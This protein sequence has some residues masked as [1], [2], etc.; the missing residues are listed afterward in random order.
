M[1][2][3]NNQYFEEEKEKRTT[4]QTEEVGMNGAARVA[5]SRKKR[6]AGVLLFVF[7]I[8]FCLSG[9]FYTLLYNNNK[10]GANGGVTASADVEFDETVSA[11]I[12]EEWALAVQ[13]LDHTHKIGDDNYSLKLWDNWGADVN[14]AYSFAYG[15]TT[16]FTNGGI[17]CPSGKTV[18]LDLNGYTVSRRL[19]AS[20]A[21][22]YVITSAGT[23]TIMDSS[24]DPDANRSDIDADGNF[25]QNGSGMITGGY[26]D[27]SSGGG[28]IL[29]T[30]GTT[31]LRSGA[32]Y[33]NRSNGLGGGG[34]SVS[35]GKLRAMGGAI[36][37]NY[38]Y[39]NGGAIFQASGTMSLSNCL[40]AQNSISAY[41][42]SAV[43]MQK[44]SAA[45]TN[46]RFINHACKNY[47]IYMDNLTTLTFTDCYM[48]GNTGSAGILATATTVS[49]TNFV[50]ENNRATNRLFHIKPTNAPTVSGGVFRNNVIS[51]VSAVIEFNVAKVVTVE[52]VLFEGNSVGS[53]TSVN[54]SASGCIV[55]HD[56][57]NYALNVRGCTFKDNVSRANG[58]SYGASCVCTRRPLTLADCVFDHNTGGQAPVW[59][60]YMAGSSYTFT[61]T[62]CKFIN[63]NS[64][65]NAS[66]IGFPKMGATTNLRGCT[67]EGN[68]GAYLVNVPVAISMAA[69]SVTNEDESVTTY[70]NIVKDNSISSALF[71]SGTSISASGCEFTDNHGAGYLLRAGTSVTATNCEFTG[72]DGAT[73]CVY[74]AAANTVTDCMFEDNAV[75]TG[76][77]YGVTTT[78]NNV[79]FAG[80]NS[81]TNSAIQTTGVTKVDN[82][83]FMGVES[84]STSVGNC[85]HATNAL[86][87]TNSTFKGNNGGVASVRAGA[88]S[89]YENLEFKNNTAQSAGGIYVGGASAFRGPI[90]VQNN[91]T[92]NGAAVF[93][94]SSASLTMSGAIRVE[95]NFWDDGGYSRAGANFYLA[96]DT[97]M[98]NIDGSLAGSR[99]Y[100]GSPRIGLFTSGFG[101]NNSGKA[102][103]IFKTDNEA[104]YE[105][106]DD[107]STGSMEGKL[108]YK[109]NST[110]WTAAV[111][112]S[113]ADGGK[114]KT[115]KLVSDWTAQVISGNYKRF[116]DTVSVNADN[117][118]SKGY[119]WVSTSNYGALYVPTGASV[120]L[121]LNGYTINR[122]IGGAIAYGVVIYIGGGTLTI[123]DSSATKTGE[124][125]QVAEGVS[126][127]LYQPNT[128]NGG[129]TGGFNSTASWAGGIFIDSGGV[130][131][132]LNLMAGTIYDNKSNAQY[133]AGGVSIYGANAVFT[134]YGGA[135]SGNVAT[136]TSNYG[137]GGV[138]AASNGTV[139]T[140]KG[141]EISG[142]TC[143]AQFGAGGVYNSATVNME[144]GR[145]TANTASNKYS[146]G[147]IFTGNACT[148]NITG[149]E[150][151][152]NAA[153][154]STAGCGGIELFGAIF[155]MS[156]AVVHNNHGVSVGGVYFY[157]SSCRG[158][159]ENGE[160]LFSNVQITENYST[161]TSSSTAGGIWIDAGVT[162]VMDS[163]AISGNWCKS[164]SENTAGGI[165]K[166]NGAGTLHLLGT[167][168]NGKNS[169]VISGNGGGSVGGINLNH[170]TVE[171][172]YFSNVDFI[173]NYSA[174]YPLAGALRFTNIIGGKLVMEGCLFDGNYI[175]ASASTSTYSHRGGVMYLA[176]CAE[177]SDCTFTNNSSTHGAGAINYGAP[178]CNQHVTLER[179]VFT[180]NVSTCS[181]YG[182]AIHTRVASTSY[183]DS[184]TLIDCTVGAEGA[185][186]AGVTTG[187]IHVPGATKTHLT[188]IG[189]SVSYNTVTAATSYAAIYVGG[190][191]GSCYFEKDASGNGVKIEHN[192]SAATTA[193]ATVYVTNGNDFHMYGGS[194]SYN[195]NTGAGSTTSSVGAGL[196]IMGS[197]SSEFTVEDVIFSGNRNENQYDTTA[198]E[199]SGTLNLIN[200]TVTENVGKS[201]I[202]HGNNQL[203]L[204][205]C[206]VTNNRTTEENSKWTYGLISSNGNITIKK[207][208]SLWHG[209]GSPESVISGN[210]ANSWGGL[211]YAY[212]GE[213]HVSDTLIN[214][215]TCANELSFIDS[216]E[217]VFDN[218]IFSDNTAGTVATAVNYGTIIC[219][220]HGAAVA[221]NNC[222]FTGN[223]GAI[224]GAVQ[225]IEGAV[226]ATDCI[227][228]NNQSLS[229]N[230]A[231]AV[232]VNGSG[233]FHMVNGSITNNTARLYRNDELS[234][235]GIYVALAGVLQLEGLVTVKDNLYVSNSE[236]DKT[237]NIYVARPSNMIQVVGTLVNNSADPQIGIYRLDLGDFTAGFGCYNAGERAEYYFGSDSA[238]SF[239]RTDT[240]GDPCDDGHAFR[241][242]MIESYDN[243]RNW[244]YYV[245]K[246]LSDGGKHYTVTL[247]GDWIAKPDG[248]TYT[249]S[250]GSDKNA[251]YYGALRVPAGANITLELNGHTLDRNLQAYT[252]EVGRSYGHVISVQGTFNLQNSGRVATVQGI[253]VGA[254]VT[255]VV[256]GARNHTAGVGTIDVSSATGKFT[257]ISGTVSGNSGPNTNRDSG[258][259]T[260]GVSVTNGARFIMV[261]G[262]IQNNYGETAGGVYVDGKSQFNLYSGSIVNNSAAVTGGVHVASGGI[263]E[264]GSDGMTYEIGSNV[265]DDDLITVVSASLGKILIEKNTLDSGDE[266]NVYTEADLLINLYGTLAAGTHVG[267]S[268]YTLS[269][270]TNNYG[271]YHTVSGEA[272]DPTKYFTSDS[273]DYFVCTEG[274]GTAAE[275]MMMSYNNRDN[276]TYAVTTSLANGGA[277]TVFKLYANP[278]TKEGWIAEK[279]GKFG[280]FFGTNTQAYLT[281]GALWVPKGANI[282]LDLRHHDLDRNLT[283]SAYENGCVIYVEGTLTVIDSLDPEEA[284]SGLASAGVP[285]KIKGGNNSTANAAGGIVV[286]HGG[287]LNLEA[288][289]ITENVAGG[290]NSVGGVYVYGSEKTHFTMKGGSVSENDGFIAGGVYV[291]NGSKSGEEKGTFTMTGGTVTQNSATGSYT[292]G[293]RI[294]NTGVLELGGSAVIDGNSASLSPKSNLFLAD[295]ADTLSD[296]AKIEIAEPFRTGANI[297]LTRTVLGTFTN[298]YGKI[299]ADNGLTAPNPDTVFHSDAAHYTVSRTGDGETLEG[300]IKCDLPAVNWSYAVQTSINNGGAA[301]RF[302]LDGNW[303][304][305]D[306]T[307]AVL[308]SFGDGVGY[309]AGRLYVPSNASIILDLKGHTI[310]RNLLDK[311]TIDNGSVFF[312]FGSLTIVDSVGGGKITG[313][314]STGTGG[315]FNAGTLEIQ[316]GSVT[317]NVSASAENAAG[318]L[319]AGTLIMSGGSITGN[320][321]PHGGVYVETDA[322]IC[323]EGTAYINGNFTDDS[324]AEASNVYFKSETGIFNITGEMKDGADISFLREG[325]GE[326]TSGFGLNNK[327]AAGGNDP[328][329]YFTSESELYQLT[330][331]G[332][333]IKCEA[334]IFSEDNEINW[335]YF[336]AK[337]LENNSTETF[338]LYQNWTA[339]TD[340]EYTTAFGDKEK[341]GYLNGGLYVPAGASMILDLQGNTIDRAL[342]E[343]IKN[344]YVFIIE[345]SLTIIDSSATNA[346]QQGVITGGFSL[347]TASAIQIGGTGSVTFNAGNITGNETE[348]ETNGTVTVNGTFSM[349]GGEIADNTG[350]VNGGVY[351]PAKSGIFKLG[352][353]SQIY[354]NRNGEGEDANIYFE[355]PKGTI[356]VDAPFTVPGTTFTV[357]RS[358]IGPFTSGYGAADYKNV[359]FVSE[360]ATYTAITKQID[361]ILEGFMD[362]DDNA[363]LWEY[364]VQTSLDNEG[365]TEDF[366]LRSDWNAEVNGKSTAF[367]TKSPYY[368][369]GA[370]YVPAGASINFDLNGYALNRGLSGTSSGVA[371]GYVMNVAGDLTLNDFS[372]KQQG[373]FTGGFSATTVNSTGGV[374]VNKGA[375]FTMTGGH[376]SDNKASGAGG[377]AVFNNGTFTMTG[378]LIG[379]FTQ[380]DKSYGKNQGLAGAVYNGAHG[381]FVMEGGVITGNEGN[382]AGGVFVYNGYGSFTMTGGSIANNTGISAGGVYVSGTAS[383]TGGEITGNEATGRKVNEGGGSGVYIAS[384]GNF[385]MTGGKVSE[386]R[387]LNGIRAYSSGVLNMGG[388][389]QVL[390]NIDQQVFDATS[391]NEYRNVYLT[392]HT[393]RINIVEPLAEGARI[394]VT[395]DGAGIFT[396]GYGLVNSDIP[397]EYFF[398][399]VSAYGV[400][401]A[402]ELKDGKSV[403]EAAIGSPVTKP[404]AV[405]GLEYDATAHEI[406]DGFDPDKMTYVKVPE[407]ATYEDG[408]FTAV[409][410]G[411]YEFR[412]SP[413]NGYCWAD[414]TGNT[415]IVTV[416][417]SPRLVEL[418]WTHLDDLVY[419][420]KVRV[421]TA[422]VINL[423]DPDDVV[424][425]AVTV[426]QPYDG[427]NAGKHWAEA[428]FVDNPNYTLRGASEEDIQTEYTINKATLD[429]SIKNDKAPYKTETKIELVDKG[430]GTLDM[431]GVNVIYSITDGSGLD[432][433]Y[434][435]EGKLYATAASGTVTIKAEVPDTTNYYAASAT[436]ELE[437]VKGTPDLDL[438][439]DEDEETLEVEY[440]ADLTLVVTGNDGFDVTLSV[441]NGEDGGKALISGN[442]L[443]GKYVGT[444]TLTIHMNENDF[445]EETDVEV[446]V[447]VVPRVVELEWGTTDKENGDWTPATEGTPIEFT[448]NGKSQAPEAKVANAVFD[449]QLKVT[450]SGQ[451]NAGSYLEQNGEASEALMIRNLDGTVN[452]N[453]KIG[454]TTNKYQDFIIN[455]AKL[456]GLNFVN[457]IVYY[458][459]ELVLE[460]EGNLGGAKVTYTVMPDTCCTGNGTIKD[461]II[462]VVDENGD[463]IEQD[464]PLTDIFVPT[465]VGKVFVKATIAESDNYYGYIDDTTDAGWI[466]EYIQI[467]QGTRKV[468]LTSTKGTNEDGIVEVVY[469]DDFAL[470]LEGVLED[471]VLE[472]GALDQDKVTFTVISVTTSDGVIG[473]ITGNGTHTFKATEAGEVKVRIDV[474]ATE[475]YRAY[476]GV[477]T[478]IVKP[479]P[480]E[481]HWSFDPN[482][483]TFNGHEQGPTAVVVNKAFV[484]D[485]VNVTVKGN[486]NAGTELTASASGLTG[487]DAHNYTL[488]DGKYTTSG[489]YTVKPLEVEVEWGNTIL[490]FTG[491]EQAPSYTVYAV[492]DGKKTDVTK[493]CGLVIDGKGLHVGSYTAT[494]TGT[495]NTNY[496]VA[497]PNPTVDFRITKSTITLEITN[498]KLIYLSDTQITFTGNIGN[499]EVTYSVVDVDPMDMWSYVTIDAKTGIAFASEYF[500]VKVRVD[501]DGTNDTYAGFVEKWLTVERGEPNLGLDDGGDEENDPYSVYYGDKLELVFTGI[502]ADTTV[503]VTWKYDGID[504]DTYEPAE[505]EEV[506]EGRGDLSFNGTNYEILGRNVGKYTLVVHTSATSLHAES[507]QEIVITVKPRPLDITWE[508]EFKYDGTPKLLKMKDETVVGNLAF[509]DTCGISYEGEALEDDYSVV[510]SVLGSQIAIGAYKAIVTVNN[511]NYCIA[512]VDDDNQLDFSII[513]GELEISIE[514]E[515]IYIDDVDE[516]G[517][518]TNILKI[519]GNLGNGKVTVSVLDDS[520]KVSF[521]ETTYVLT[522]I[523]VGKV[524]VHIHIDETA[525]YGE[526]DG[527][528]E[529]EVKKHETDVELESTEFEYGTVVELKLTGDGAKDGENDRDVTYEIKEINVGGTK[530]DASIEDADF[531]P[532]WVGKVIIHVVVAGSENYDDAEFDVEVTIK[533]RVVEL[534][535]KV[536][537]GGYVYDG[538][539]QGPTATVK[540]IVSW[541]GEKDDVTVKVKGHV[542]AGVDVEAT[543]EKLEGDASENY[544]LPE[545][546]LT[547]QFTIDR[548]VLSYEWRYYQFDENGEIVKDTE[549]KPVLI[550]Y[551]KFELEY[552]GKEIAP[553]PYITSTLYYNEE[554]EADD[555]CEIEVTGKQINVIQGED[556][557]SNPYTATAFKPTNDNYRLADAPYGNE[558]NKDFIIVKATPHIKLTTTEA[559]FGK[560]LELK[561]TGNVGKGTETYTIVDPLDEAGQKELTDNSWTAGNAFIKNGTNVFT[562][563]ELGYVRVKISVAETENSFAAE[564]YAWVKV[565][566]GEM[567]FEIDKDE[568]IYG[569]DLEMELDFSKVVGFGTDLTEEGTKFT[570]KPTVISGTISNGVDETKGKAEEKTVGDYYYTITA[571]GAGKVEVTI[572]VK[573]NDYYKDT[574]LTFTVTIKPRTITITEWAD[575]TEFVY[576][577][578]EQYPAIKGLDNLASWDKVEDI[579]E[580]VQV[581]GYVDVTPAGEKYVATAVKSLNDNYV[582]DTADAESLKS[583]EYVITA[584]VV[585]FEW[586]YYEFDEDGNIVTDEDGNPVLIP[587]D[588]FKLPYTGEEI[589][590]I[591]RITNLPKDKDG[592]VIGSCEINVGGKEINVG[593]DYTATADSVTNSNYTLA[594]TKSETSVNFDIVVSKPNL[595]LTYVKVDYN[596]STGKYTVSKNQNLYYGDTV[597]LVLT[598]NIGEGEE[599]YSLDDAGKGTFSTDSTDLILGNGNVKQY[600]FLKVEYVG[601]ITVKVEV[602]ET[603]NTEAAETELTLNV[604]KADRNVQIWNYNTEAYHNRDTYVTYGVEAALMFKGLDDVQAE[605]ITYLSTLD[606]PKVIYPYTVRLVSRG[607][608][609][610]KNNMFPIAP[611]KNGTKYYSVYSLYPAGTYEEMRV[612]VPA[613][614]NYNA[615]VG[616]F[617]VYTKK[618]EIT[619]D[620]QKSEF[621]YNGKQQVPT[622]NLIGL[623]KEDIGYYENIY[624][625]VNFSFT[626]PN[627]SAQMGVDAGTYTAT[628]TSLGNTDY[629]YHSR[630]GNIYYTIVGSN[631]SYEYTIG[632]ADLKLVIT[633][634]KAA[635]GTD[636]QLKVSGNLGGGEVTYQLL[637][638]GS[639]SATLNGDILTPTGL[640]TVLVRASVPETKNY[641]AATSEITVITIGKPYAPIDVKTLEVMYG[642]ELTVVVDNNVE[643][644]QVLL[645]IANGTG[646][647]ELNGYVLTG[648]G[649]GTATLT[650]T[651]AETAT[652]QQTTIT[653]TV[654]IK[655]RP[656]EIEWDKTTLKLVY[657]GEVQAPRAYVVSG[658]INGDT[659]EVKVSGGQI[660]AG[661]Y[662]AKAV[663][664]TNP[665]Y[666][667]NDTNFTTPFEIVG[668]KIDV[669]L[670]NKVA[671]IGD[672]L[673][674]VLSGN[675][676]GG[677]VTYTILNT[678]EGAAELTGDNL[679]VLNPI[680]TGEVIVR[681]HVDATPNTTACDKDEI[682]TIKKRELNLEFKTT[683]VVYGDTLELDILG[684]TGNGEVSYTVTNHANETQGRATIQNDNELVAK[685]V[686]EVAVTVT[687]AVTDRYEET[688]LTEIITIKPRP[689]EIEWDKSKTLIYNGEE[690][691]PS[692]TVKPSSLVGSDTCLVTKIEG[693]IDAGTDNVATVIE[694][695]NENYTVEDGVNISTTYT[696][697]P[698]TV[699]LE[700]QKD[701]SFV[702][703]GT[704]QV[705]AAEVTNKA[706]RDKD[707][708][709]RVYVDGET[710]ANEWRK[711]EGES[712]VRATATATSIGIS[713]YTLDNGITTCTNLTV[714]YDI[715][716]APVNLEWKLDSSTNLTVGTFFDEKGEIVIAKSTRDGL[717]HNVQNNNEEDICWVEV[718]VSDGSAL[719]SA[720]ATFAA[721]RA[722]DTSAAVKTYKVEAF[723]VSNK[724]YDLDSVESKNVTRAGKGITAEW[725]IL[726]EDGEF[727]PVEGDIEFIY[728]GYE[729]KPAYRLIGIDEEDKD[730]V[731][732]TYELSE[733]SIN[734]GEYTIY[735]KLSGDKAGDYSF[736]NPDDMQKAFKIVPKEITVKVASKDVVMG[737][738]DAE[739][740]T[741]KLVLKNQK[742]SSWLTITSD[743]LAEPDKTKAIGDIFDISKLFTE[744]SF[745]QDGEETSP[746]IG[747]PGEYDIHLDLIKPTTL[748]CKDPK[749]YVVTNFE[750]EEK[751]K[752]TVTAGELEVIKLTE[753]STY[754]F[755]TEVKEVRNDIPYSYRRSY[756]T[757]GWTHGEDDTDLDYAVIG[758]ISK[759]TMI[760][761]FIG[762]I[763]E[764]Q[765][766]SIRVHRMIDGVDTLLY[767]CGTYNE[768]L[769]TSQ[770]LIATGTWVELVDSEGNVLDTVYLSVLGDA[771]GDGYINS[772]DKGNIGNY[773]L[774]VAIDLFDRVEYR[775]AGYIMNGGG[776][777]SGDAGVAGNV[778]FGKAT[779]EDYFD[780]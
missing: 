370:L 17:A 695:D 585:E 62:R 774:G 231:G 22:G 297:H 25:V 169:I 188:I 564:T 779:M 706:L 274:T 763:D 650:V 677:K 697:L 579:A 37:G 550:P 465:K 452:P 236:A 443:T 128:G 377:G 364:A 456:T 710:H 229:P 761:V 31:T 162:L 98:L 498:E 21:N 601:T 292:G 127:P 407:G 482:G 500:R 556:P 387:G 304:A 148:L 435:T 521:N 184:L 431:T 81:F 480:V 609:Y 425:V 11:A 357:T 258:V 120:I 571:K 96:G 734:A 215:N 145:I 776:I 252:G 259:H 542:N 189:G 130:H 534:E 256:T 623:A 333:G 441:A 8:L 453:Y 303:T 291:D 340:D 687:V 143:A 612:E 116:N 247:Y 611:S 74:S 524:K 415:I 437:L 348:S 642:D 88:N 43:R 660:A 766:K 227:I 402:T 485:V 573:G 280:T 765:R 55:A 567:A 250:F 493:V 450:T 339:K 273:S 353:S 477:A 708:S 698:R 526:F 14:N 424:N 747:G 318:V 278:T 416:V 472:G 351:I 361:G 525:D 284:K 288:G 591:A 142:N 566:K 54:G 439:K 200:C 464:D 308:T 429:L 754:Q 94:H 363:A 289:C 76:L 727:V 198:I 512:G 578:Q 771:N 209:N 115:C 195:I 577:A 253:N 45:F 735:L 355:S 756:K 46:V 749:N 478:V 590:P 455:K 266:K 113:L 588:E 181:G 49:V 400:S 489:N 719:S 165:Y 161:T 639:G 2:R 658:L 689:V 713:N 362:T 335:S 672:T 673:K 315:I 757:L 35:A 580:D 638:G 244:Q 150:I 459:E 376:I 182:G 108:F 461:R 375:T 412:F 565:V 391:P 682:V 449:D 140:M 102:T 28:G 123:I 726:D 207:D 44:G 73:Y 494:A 293:V 114:T 545:E 264:I 12:S 372:D 211:I 358:A 136:S 598:G 654:I 286:A 712:E 196:Y 487:K 522:P 685:H 219:A 646:S 717:Y 596:E 245:N 381:E 388:T 592:K 731:I 463:E 349:Y 715:D 707:L 263:F 302:T 410:A 56:Q 269:L 570:E 65:A 365:A 444:V 223:C 700:W 633:T 772:G 26:S 628:V 507:T 121:D 129:I 619:I 469:G 692:A 9:I 167:K 399:D 768:A 495:E 160:V 380:G 656:V 599:H 10:G 502:D 504:L 546:G 87:L 691:T 93:V 413:K 471:I 232:Y 82:C 212:K 80:A 674:L 374:L 473:D 555:E 614:E 551:E 237:V 111:Q 59:S 4:V 3:K 385:T 665:N 408:K 479:K 622:V 203:N 32:I 27:A 154:S 57:V 709:I 92:R 107:T 738:V 71:Y 657:N 676:G 711:A 234:S 655:P 597:L 531:S 163:G 404:T 616:Y 390:N 199:T 759:E 540:N 466:K 602:E 356:Y 316:A 185:G 583:G 359:T 300:F 773:Y 513:L 164:T 514:P 312:V 518:G 647:A 255:G 720:M 414:G 699:E 721:V 156:N 77:I 678:G 298:N 382:N 457:T 446:T 423:A 563:D 445:Y 447:K 204:I 176:S 605:F 295:K 131:G 221:L 746:A 60:Y 5:V 427:K 66:A 235:G 762:N 47:L 758:S 474:A 405:M 723:D 406:I 515:E 510:V 347:N 696:I 454:D 103:D 635:L 117:A 104:L 327:D 155:N 100:V 214:G 217:N 338:T 314:N 135:I 15:Q 254:P 519:I 760:D 460:L 448:Y 177:I 124:T 557:W 172:T 705:P 530:G 241:E 539:E 42:G 324:K 629:G 607:V 584:L 86:T 51:G 753:E 767:D 659:S 337:S 528:F 41:Y 626:S 438:E 1:K 277:E 496:K 574:E 106:T 179:C 613:T 325:L 621:T 78:V 275:A 627:A 492:L 194:V 368:I 373:V 421:P 220:D 239:V 683:E 777:V 750:F 320:Y 770:K 397:S 559:P 151:S 336:V 418:E 511:P 213:T 285:G 543:A 166:T 572:K 744:P 725:G 395:R 589:A 201:L 484:D 206:T 769:L 371:N 224:S 40:I 701:A 48:S 394:G 99:I 386:N 122:A 451:T 675:I 329:K 326:V 157:G 301:E 475:N 276:W 112:E 508:N 537:E 158:A 68:A 379:S 606:G 670:V 79:N 714:L 587:Y 384:T 262:A 631:L 132:V 458:G 736:E 294:N 352:G 265:G 668:A 742:W 29:V 328:L 30:G 643:K 321:G 560:D 23:F 317:G 532:L 664:P 85:I 310:D 369:N 133:T 558:H 417:I 604:V 630:N 740:F 67:F 637:T 168:E 186:N 34:I 366:K 582:L 562:P 251:F 434:L 210:T 702:Y 398:S 16:G 91:T 173:G 178:G 440:G 383:M 716:Q 296:G 134:M 39:N 242:G 346:E 503:T 497:T 549:G 89:T 745:W 58:G 279:G 729:Q 552:T 249:T 690:Q 666:C 216:G 409:N 645:G 331:Q 499:G 523:A 780:C 287:T 53:Y 538:T 778:Y 345:G 309:N 138:Y 618:K 728:N 270:F 505:D 737:Y 50:A 174:S 137:G 101:T 141:G 175:S 428:S 684:N 603:E 694:L 624:K 593:T 704:E 615:Y 481:L 411:S 261:N 732:V 401:E 419:T 6:L 125:V 636:L 344:G 311:A 688:T 171:V 70:K 470:S 389:A 517:N 640:G 240:E 764:S 307:D 561:I 153:T 625:K 733:S 422:T 222:T 147:G 257:F 281:S 617:R 476:T 703:D 536:E 69:S 430:I 330:K 202:V 260:G 553:I 208:A 743:D 600:E 20:M 228:R 679:D 392:V 268:R 367:G 126:V 323:V 483:Y 686:G 718:T 191:N 520:G 97:N 632:R 462:T 722:A 667:L 218:V 634:T 775:L 490:K 360:D 432:L 752:L 509:K 662:T 680:E 246:S 63:G 282:V 334:V 180:N 341:A 354:E 610:R 146:G 190:N 488:E 527:D 248:G 535:W 149:G 652:Y 663:S 95:N 313:G 170:T 576:N 641:N 681:I 608:W 230:S 119:S 343:A 197:D 19:T 436:K 569:D 152:G 575:D 225:A 393:Q 226:T 271:Q 620:W 238:Y 653:R 420:G 529:I 283:S 139:F 110:L 306:V 568:V 299:Y 267:I 144:G 18:T 90:T 533:P 233:T 594:G 506:D 64:G 342:G 305:E 548:A 649:A 13:G 183:E 36:V 755:I 516:D 541:D 193:G 290:L 644:G 159:G 661:K 52:D 332:T 243:E 105:V 396:S 724:D 554:N 491:E 748:P 693:A 581:K 730:D 442:V 33:G 669:S 350:V 192:T 75:K 501:V 118:H 426:M 83:H 205:N 741:K 486:Q 595:K 739:D 84:S 547:K 648:T 651:V 187:A 24:E 378:G 586:V 403:K 544:A 751:G 72:N 7:S 468:T 322:T 467:L 38:A 109:T 671:Y 319:N 61:A 272:A 433:S